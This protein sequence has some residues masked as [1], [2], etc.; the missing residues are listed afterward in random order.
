MNSPLFAL[1]VFAGIASVTLGAAVAAGLAREAVRSALAAALCFVGIGLL[2]IWLQAE[3]LG[4]IQL[5]VYVGAIAI[6]IVFVILLTRHSD[7]ESTP[8]LPCARTLISGISVAVLLFG[9]LVV[10]VSRSNL[11]NRPPAENA[12]IDIAQV[13]FELL[14]GGLWPLFLTGILLTAALIGGVGLA[15]AHCDKEDPQ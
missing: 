4:L 12:A 5:L 10:A 8:P 13:G 15:L 2:Y 9:S 7:E 14:S 3:F 11:L 6:L 1:L